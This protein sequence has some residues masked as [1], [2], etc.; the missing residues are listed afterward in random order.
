MIVL[1]NQLFV[2]FFCECMCVYVLFI[3]TISISILCFARL[4]HI[5]SNLMCDFCN[6][7]IFENQKH[8][9]PMS[10]KF[11]WSVTYSFDITDR[12]FEHITGVFNTHFHVCISLLLV[13]VLYQI[14]V[15][16]KPMSSLW[17]LWTWFIKYTTRWS[18]Y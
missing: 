16:A 9:R 15:I 14:K 5:E 8:C 2:I 18:W 12:C 1:Y 10:Y 7:V 11:L 4:C 3:Y 13:C 17:N 6:C